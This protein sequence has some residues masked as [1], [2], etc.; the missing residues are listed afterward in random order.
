MLSTTTIDV[1]DSQEFHVVHGTAR[2]LGLAITVVSKAKEL[3]FFGGHG[4]HG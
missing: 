3:V 1:V 4:Y 2:T